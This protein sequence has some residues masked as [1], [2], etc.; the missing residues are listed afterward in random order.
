M[1]GW[2]RNDRGQL[3]TGGG[4]VVDMYSMAEMPTPIEGQLEGRR[5]SKIAAGDGHAACITEAGELFYW[6][7]KIHLEPVLVNALLHTKCTDVVCGGN[8]L[9][10]TTEEG[11]VYA[12]GKGKNGVLGVASKSDTWEPVLI[13]GLVG[14][15]VY[16]IAAGNDHILCLVEDA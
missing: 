8:Y 9:C 11:Y 1:V 15:Q 4:I 2:G 5:V 7:M 10:V 16:D 14:K 6:G 13:E 3:G 12:L